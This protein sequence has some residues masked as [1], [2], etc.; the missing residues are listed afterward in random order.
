MVPYNCPACSTNKFEE[1]EIIDIKEQHFLYAPD[2]IACQTK[3]NSLAA[4]T[5][6]Y[7]KMR[8]CL[9]CQLE[10]AFPF[11]APSSEWYDLA[12]KE[13]QLYPSKRWEF[14]FVLNQIRKDDSILELGCGSGEFLKICSEKGIKSFGLDFSEDAINICK[15]NGLQASTID[16]SVSAKKN[17]IGAT[18]FTAFHV[19]E[20]MDNPSELFRYTKFQANQGAI[21]WVAIPSIN[22]PSRCFGLVDYLDQ[23]PHHMTR[24]TV[25]ALKHIS[26][27]EGWYLDE[28]FYEP[29][30]CKTKCWYISTNM[31]IYKNL[32]PI[33]KKIRFFEV[34]AR[35]I[36]Y[37]IAGLI[38][39]FKYKNMTGFTLLAK[40][41]LK[42]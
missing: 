20:H 37:P 13:L 8:K 28:T 15:N 10:F 16:L 39:S 19:L 2:N 18:V 4:Q 33:F 27:K 40:F 29:I 21:L 34:L 30:S 36:L 41:H 35:V 3:L 1:L 24:W 22:R 9:N 17:F 14:N 7:Y 23:P 38:S 42:S 6:G 12:Y 5:D 25:S 26:Q 32:Q 31:K 11:Q